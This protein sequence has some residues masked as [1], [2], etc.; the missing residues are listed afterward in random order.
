MNIE[1]ISLWTGYAV[2]TIG[3]VALV[4]GALAGLAL[5]GNAVQ[6]TIKD[7]FGGWTALREFIEWRRA[8]DNPP[9]SFQARVRTWAIACFGEVIPDDIQERTYRFTEEALELAQACG[10]SKEDVLK[11]VEY[12]FNRP[13]GERTEEAGAAKLTLAALCSAIQLDLDEVG[14]AELKRVWGKASVIRAKQAAKPKDSPLPQ[15]V[16]GPVLR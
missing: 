5:L 8:Q 14:D 10:C 9:Q 13:V 7:H 6:H 11:L 3:A 12:V 2:L 1:S 15:H 4:L 16:D